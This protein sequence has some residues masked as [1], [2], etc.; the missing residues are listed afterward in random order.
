MLFIGQE[1]ST[2]LF[3]RMDNE[4]TRYFSQAMAGLGPIISA[5]IE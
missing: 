4:E 5:I 1:N 3:K 2:K